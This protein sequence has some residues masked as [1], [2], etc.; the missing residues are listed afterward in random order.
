[1]EKENVV[2]YTM[3]NNLAFKMGEILSFMTTWMNLENIK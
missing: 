1:M 2:I 3:E